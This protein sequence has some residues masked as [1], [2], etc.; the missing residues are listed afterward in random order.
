MDAINITGCI[1]NSVIVPGFGSIGIHRHATLLRLYLKTCTWLRMENKLV[2]RW[3]EMRNPTG[4]QQTHLDGQKA[5]FL[6]TKSLYFLENVE[7]QLIFDLHNP[8]VI[9]WL[10]ST[11]G[12]S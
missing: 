1:H 2:T 5:F 7:M 9:T 12:L 6:E 4:S 3:R 8:F 10:I 11:S